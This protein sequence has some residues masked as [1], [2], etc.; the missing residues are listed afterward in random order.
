MI[1]QRFSWGNCSW[2]ISW[3]LV[4]AGRDFGARCSPW[5]SARCRYLGKARC[6]PASQRIGLLAAPA[7][8]PRAEHRPPW[9]LCRLSAPKPVLLPGRRGKVRVDVSSEGTC[10]E[11]YCN[12]LFSQWLVH[13]CAWPGRM[14]P[15]FFPLWPSFLTALNFH[16]IFGG[17]PLLSSSNHSL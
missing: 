15:L 12:A 7:G 13:R 1:F 14:R 4:P 2:P 10:R 11:T 16:P 6:Q 8:Q 5:D 9:S 17:S 3:G